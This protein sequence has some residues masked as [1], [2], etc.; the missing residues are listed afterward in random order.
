MTLIVTYSVIGIHLKL[1]FRKLKGFTGQLLKAYNNASLSAT[2]TSKK[3]RKQNAAVFTG[4]H[5]ELML[6]KTAQETFVWCTYDKELQS[7]LL[8]IL[9]IYCCN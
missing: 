4:I 7:I 5:T 8:S 2:T 3:D 6:R 9:H 1:D